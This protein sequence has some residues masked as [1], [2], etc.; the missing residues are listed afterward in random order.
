MNDIDKVLCL[1]HR[2]CIDGLAAAWAL[3]HHFSK[4]YVRGKVQFL[5]T[6]Y[7]DPP[8]MESIDEHTQVFILDFSYPV[9]DIQRIIQ[10]ARRVVVLDHHPRSEAI[11]EEINR[12][13]MDGKEINGPHRAHM[14]YC[15]DRSGALMT[16]EYFFPGIEPPVIL[17]HVSDRDLWRFKMPRTREMI[18]ALMTYPL[19]LETWIPLFNAHRC[20]Y[21]LT[22]F[23][24]SPQC[25]DTTA[26]RI[27]DIGVDWA[28]A[29]TLRCI[30]FEGYT[31]IPLI[32]CPHSVTSDAL[33]ALYSDVPFA[34]AYYDMGSGRK[35]S[36]RSNKETGINVDELA[37]KYN[38]GG[39]AHAAGFVVP[40][41]HPLAKV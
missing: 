26:G 40:R 10:A 7:K 1:Y 18:D 21:T 12:W 24:Q 20:G 35:F 27:H 31:D 23:L 2:D 16:W 6:D 37:Q 36:L 11:A 3:N 14:A 22:E 41:D 39:H 9:E 13:L 5:A 8:P 17:Y 19:T 28:I 38:G 4:S 15:N 34:M 32:N 30:D 29:N 25:L 33:H